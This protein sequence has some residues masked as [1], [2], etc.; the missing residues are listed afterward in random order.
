MAHAKKEVI[1]VNFVKDTSQPERR[2]TRG[3]SVTI[4]T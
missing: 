2:E 3:A 4:G 1:G